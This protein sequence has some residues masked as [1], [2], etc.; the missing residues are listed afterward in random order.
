MK[1]KNLK[2]NP[3]TKEIEVQFVLIN[4]KQ[5]VACVELSCN[6]EDWFYGFWKVHTTTNLCF[7]VDKTTATKL[8]NDKK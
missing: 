4:A 3:S 8:F 1:I 6:K 5:I 2:W 7:I